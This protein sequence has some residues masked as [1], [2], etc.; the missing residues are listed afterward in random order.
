G[1][2][3]FKKYFEQECKKRDIP[4]FVLPPR[5]PK[6]NGCVERANRTHREE[7]YEVNEVE[8]SLIE[9]NKQL[10]EWQYIYNHIRPHQALDYL[11]PHEYY[12]K[13]KQEEEEK[14]H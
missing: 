4:L 1:G 6:L 8:L 9:H 13:W 12:Q 10:E 2:S 5:S 14:C 3:E 7:F 11:T